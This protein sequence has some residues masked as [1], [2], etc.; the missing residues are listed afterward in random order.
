[1]NGAKRRLAVKEMLD[2]DGKIPCAHFLDQYIK[3]A[4]LKRDNYFI[5][6][7]IGAQPLR[8]VIFFFVP[9]C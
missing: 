1:M 2:N 3:T 5:W 9:L 6:L 8:F 4:Q 7:R